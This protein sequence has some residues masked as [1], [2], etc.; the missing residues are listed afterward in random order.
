[1]AAGS[2]AVKG[3]LMLVKR[4]TSPIEVAAAD[5]EPWFWLGNVSVS[6][7]EACRGTH[8]TLPETALRVIPSRPT[9]NM[10]DAVWASIS[11]MACGWVLSSWP[12]VS[13]TYEYLACEIPDPSNDA[14]L[15]QSA[16]RGSFN[17]Q[18]QSCTQR[19]ASGRNRTE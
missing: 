11:A 1:M 2:S 3:W 18:G 10:A 13:N 17:F 12:T 9:G 19:F 14:G 5:G 8:W 6:Y 15:Q 7:A 16:Q 4:S